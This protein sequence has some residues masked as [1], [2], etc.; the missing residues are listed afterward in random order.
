MGIINS[1]IYSWTF[2]VSLSCPYAA[3]SLHTR[4]TDS[5]GW[6]SRRVFIERANGVR[7]NEPIM[8]WSS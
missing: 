7:E 8:T 4:I 5:R 6:G 1:D 2:L 3:I